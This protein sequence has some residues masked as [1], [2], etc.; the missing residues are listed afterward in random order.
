MKN[1]KCYLDI[2]NQLK[3]LIDTK[4]VDPNTV[5][6][7]Y[8][9]EKVYLNLIN[10]YTDIISKGRDADGNHIYDINTDFAKYIELN[11]LDDTIAY[12][13][14]SMIGCFENSLKSFLSHRYCKRI[15]ASGD[16]ETKDYKWVQDYLDN[17]QVFDLYPMNMMLYE[18]AIVI[19][20]E[21][22]INLRKETLN[23]ILEKSTVN[24]TSGNDMVK[25]Y[26]N[27]YGYVPFYVVINLLSISKLLTLFSLLPNDD[28]KE[29]ILYFA[30]ISEKDF[31]SSKISKFEKDFLRINNI[32]NKVSHCEPIFPYILNIKNNNFQS[33]CQLV[34][35]L[36]TNYCASNTFMQLPF[37]S[38]KPISFA[39]DPVVSQ[40]VNRINAV[41]KILS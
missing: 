24:I 33:F 34:E 27:E 9:K 8:L 13:L 15:S 18:G 35:R 17:Q 28:K 3:H 2:N 21:S 1:E 12:F 5:S 10:P 20:D 38:I 39:C 26:S 41:V 40:K 19:A 16:L 37:G 23:D 4:N 29:F 11:V 32:R 25:H 14:R 36:K 31:N 22:T 6:D 7:S 30:K